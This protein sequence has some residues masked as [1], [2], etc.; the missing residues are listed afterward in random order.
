MS[1]ELLYF[2]TFLAG[3][4]SV[5]APSTS[6]ST[7][8]PSYTSI[9]T[10]VITADSISLETILLIGGCSFAGVF[11]CACLWLRHQYSSVRHDSDRYDTNMLVGDLDEDL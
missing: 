10:P 11:M 2:A 7:P 3:V 1:C 5:P 6:I 9:S 8:A 4:V